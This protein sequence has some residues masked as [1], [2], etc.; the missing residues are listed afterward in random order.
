MSKDLKELRNQRA[1]KL[2]EAQGIMDK[3]GKAG[4]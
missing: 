2:D 3:A 1:Q 4:R